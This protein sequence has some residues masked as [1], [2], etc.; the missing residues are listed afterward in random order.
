MLK[1]AESILDIYNYLPINRSLLYAGIIFHDVGKIAEIGDYFQN[2]YSLRGELIGHIVI[3]AEVVGK[4]GKKLEVDPKK[5]I[6][7]QHLILASHGKLENASPVEP[8]TIESLI[9]S[10]LDNLDAKIG[11]IFIEMNKLSPSENSIQEVRLDG[12]LLNFHFHHSKK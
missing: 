9:L 11:A 2:K 4:V 12:K 5:I 10:H 3:G 8:K 1:V 6:L 7:L